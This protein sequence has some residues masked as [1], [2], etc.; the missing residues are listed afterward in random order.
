MAG[1]RRNLANNVLFLSFAALAATFQCCLFFASILM[2]QSRGQRQLTAQA[3]EKY[4]A[5]FARLRRIRRRI[6]IIITLAKFA[7]VT[8]TRPRLSGLPLNVETLT[9]QNATRSE[10]S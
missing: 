1:D 10:P 4:N 5:T 6:I 7:N 8:R 2:M 9:S 3:T